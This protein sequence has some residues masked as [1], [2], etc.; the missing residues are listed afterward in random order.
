MAILWM[1]LTLQVVEVAPSLGLPDTLREALYEDAVCYCSHSSVRGGGCTFLVTR[2]VGL[3]STSVQ[4]TMLEGLQT[5]ATWF[6]ASRWRVCLQLRVM[7][8]PI[9]PFILH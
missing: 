2:G 1:I 7:R 5:G 4:A 6:E 8:S 9:A 3:S